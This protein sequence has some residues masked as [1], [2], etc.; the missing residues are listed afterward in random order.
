MAKLRLAKILE[1]HK[2][3]CGSLARL[4]DEIT[5]AN[6]GQRS[7]EKRKLNSI[8]KSKAKSLTLADIEALDV[9]LT[10]FGQSLA[11]LPLLDTNGIVQALVEKGKVDIF[12]PTRVL[13]RRD[14]TSVWDVRALSGIVE[15]IN[16][17]WP[18]TRI[19]LQEEAERSAA[20]APPDEDWAKL[21]DDLE[22]SCCCLGS[23]L[24]FGLAEYMLAEMF[25][26]QPFVPLPKIHP[27]LP[28]HFVWYA[29]PDKSKRKNRQSHFALTAKDLT[30]GE[31]TLPAADLPQAISERKAQAFLVGETIYPVQ[32]D[33]PKRK[34][35][36]VVVAQRRERGQIWVVIAGLSGPGTYAAARLLDELTVTL[37]GSELG[38]VA[39]PVF[40]VVE[41]AVRMNSS[42]TSGD[43]REVVD[44][45]ILVEPQVWK[46]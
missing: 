21:V 18:T 33:Q 1:E 34:D 46:G 4:S 10:R 45:R 7:I 23:P 30:A 28:F 2:R 36:G 35:Y 16:R 39:P 22:A 20:C 31:L 5:E 43:V 32:L 37:P 8:I 3:R 41:S 24:V 27:K 12:V 40:A 13:E 15:S 26:V 9:F 29:D 14:Y 19:G 25:G 6:D 17:R 44:Q 42:K 38:E 11:R